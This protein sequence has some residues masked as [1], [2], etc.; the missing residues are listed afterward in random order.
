MYRK[1]R[2]LQCSSVCL[3]FKEKS[4]KECEDEPAGVRMYGNYMERKHIYSPWFAFPCMLKQ[5]WQHLVMRRLQKFYAPDYT[6]LQSW[7][8]EDDVFNKLHAIIPS[9]ET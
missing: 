1:F 5:R 4:L 8:A 7:R 9:S 3:D 6:R 2:T